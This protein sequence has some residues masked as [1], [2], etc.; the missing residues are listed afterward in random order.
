MQTSNLYENYWVNVSYKERYSFDAAARDRF[1]AIKNVWDSLKIPET[2]LDFG[3]GNG[4]LTYWMHKNG[5]GKEICGVDIS[6]T[7]IDNAN[8]MFARS[9]LTYKKFDDFKT[10]LGNKKFDVVVSSHVLEHIPNPSN[11]L[12]EMRSLSELFIFEVPLEKCLVQN[13]IC[14]LTGRAQSD[15]P[16]GHV[17]FWTK[18]NFKQ[19]LEENGFIILREKHYASAPFSPFSSKFKCLIERVAL[20]ILGLELYSKIMSTHYAV[21]VRPALS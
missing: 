8:T 19:L 6:Q 11:I 1:P 14:T 21:L 5:F 15:N 10:T 13:L 9:G 12:K 18:D 2:V 7:G 17:N 4:V 20:N 16:V 3:C